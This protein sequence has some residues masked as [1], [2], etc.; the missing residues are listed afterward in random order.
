M[1]TG[2]DTVNIVGGQ[3]V[4]DI[5]G[6]NGNDTMNFNVNG[7]F[8]Y[9]YH[10]REFETANFNSGRSNINGTLDAPAVNVNPGATLGGTG[11]IN[12]NVINDG[13][14]SPGHSI[15]TLTINGNFT[16]NPGGTLGA[17]LA[18]N[19][20]SS[21]LQVNG[22]ATLNGGTLATTLDRGVFQNGTT[23]TVLAATGGVTGQFSQSTLLTPSP[24]LSLQTLLLPGSVQ[25]QII[26]KPYTSL[27]GGM[28]YNQYVTAVNLDK[29]LPTASGDWLNV[30][31]VFD[32]DLPTSQAVRNALDQLHPEM[33]DALAQVALSGMQLRHAGLERRW[34]EMRTGMPGYDMA[35]L[36]N[37]R[38]SLGLCLAA[39]GPAP[40]TAAATADDKRLGVFALGTGLMGDQDTRWEGG[41]LGVD[42]TGYDFTSAGAV[43]GVDYR[44]DKNF[45]VGVSGTYTH[46]WVDIDRSGSEANID[47]F[48][49]GPYVSYCDGGFYADASV[50][51]GVNYYES[52]RHIRFG[53][54]NRKATMDTDGLNLC[55]D[56]GGGYMFKQGNWTVGPTGR[57]VYSL[58][59][60]SG[61][62]E[63]GAGALN[64]LV[65]DRD[66]HS[67]RSELGGR[68][69]YTVQFGGF[70]LV[71][72]TRVRWS[73]E[74]LND[75][76]DITAQF[77]G[78]GAGNFTAHAA[79]PSRESAFLGVGLT[80]YLKSSFSAFLNY[81]VDVG[82]KD[83]LTHGGSVGFRVRF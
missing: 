15:G 76:H 11:L 55:A 43:I 61:F 46:S 10:I 45:L 25:I 57:L 68:V 37:D 78:S 5:V 24:F 20:T 30:L 77:I 26:R 48:A 27:L 73:H 42:Q 66:V 33:Y 4:G 8:N 9:D 41:H 21:L 52:S 82:R 72:E 54:L 51:A 34:Q 14:V 16:Q 83:N 50:T 6:G 39:P 3:I 64:L 13:T 60:I 74:F 69:A 17:E 53:G 19:G 23:F 18:A 49:I 65:Q 31:P 56:L 75:N 2:D 67:L 22:A 12:G 63:K 47:G 81:D 7:T 58:V 28:T 80:A 35:S 79:S 71:P 1:G 62:K 38:G 32:F 59:E 36:F 29:I 44:V 70:K 40:V